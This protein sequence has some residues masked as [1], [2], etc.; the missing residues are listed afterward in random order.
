MKNVLVLVLGVVLM[1]TVGFAREILTPEQAV[2]YIQNAMVKEGLK[3][4]KVMC[5]PTTGRNTWAVA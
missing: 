3:G 1:T 5:A 4:L 2:E